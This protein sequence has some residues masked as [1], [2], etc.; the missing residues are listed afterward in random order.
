MIEIQKLLLVTSISVGMT[1]SA[2]AD[3]CIYQPSKDYG[4]V[5][6]I[7]TGCST[8]EMTRISEQVRNQ[9]APNAG[10]FEALSKKL[11]RIIQLLEERR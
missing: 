8:S 1:I 4:T 3:N 7:G 11:D 10:D 5:M 6:F 9:R 2:R